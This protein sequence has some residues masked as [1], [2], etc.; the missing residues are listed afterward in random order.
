MKVSTLKAIPKYYTGV[1]VVSTVSFARFSNT[2]FYPMP[3]LHSVGDMINCN[4]ESEIV[5]LLF[6]LEFSRKSVK[7]VY[8]RLQKCVCVCVCVNF[9]CQSCSLTLNDD[10]IMA[11]QHSVYKYSRLKLFIYNHSVYNSKSRMPTCSTLLSV[12]PF[13]SSN[14]LVFQKLTTIHDT[15]CFHCACTLQNTGLQDQNSKLQAKKKDHSS[16]S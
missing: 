6:P 7:S 10:V 12:L 13:T 8:A 15:E 16:S 5:L 9:S 4:N 1:L 3:L 2:S 11:V 14:R